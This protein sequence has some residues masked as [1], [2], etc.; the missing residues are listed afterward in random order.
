MISFEE[1]LAQQES[2]ARTRAAM[3][4]GKPA[5]ADL[6]FVKPP[7]SQIKQCEKLSDSNVKTI[8]MDASKICGKKK[9]KS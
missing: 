9:K 8:N 6:M 2:S 5:Q 7:Y 1:W 4:P 3:D